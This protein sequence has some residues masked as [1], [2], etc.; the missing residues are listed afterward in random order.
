[1][2]ATGDDRERIIL[3]PG[4][5]GGPQAC[6][7]T[8]TAAGGGFGRLFGSLP[9]CDADEATIAEL[10]GWL[11]DGEHAFID[12][13]GIPAGFT[14]FGQFVD[15]D[16]TFDHLSRLGKVNEPVALV[17]LR[18]PCLDLDSVYGAGPLDQPFLYDWEPPNARGA[19]LLLGGDLLDDGFAQCDLPRNGQGR[20][21]IGDPRN[22]DNLIV[23]QLHLLFIRF[24]NAVVDHLCSADHATNAELFNDARRIVCWHYQWIVAHEYLRHI[25]GRSLATSVLEPSVDGGPETGRR[26][27]YSLERAPFIPVEFSGAVF[28]FSHSMVRKDYGINGN[29]GR[30]V[31]IFPTAGERDHL[32]GFR[33][34]PSALVIEWDRF[35]DLVHGDDPL[36]PQHS[37]RIDTSIAPALFELPVPARPPFD[38]VAGEDAKALPWLDLQ[39]GRA[40]GL[41]SGQDVAAV[42][43]VRALGDEQLRLGEIGSPSARATLRRAAPLWYYTLCEAATGEFGDTGQHLGP[44]GGRIVAE[45]LVGLLE[46]DP[47]SYLRQRPAWRPELPGA[48]AGDFTMADLI[49]FTLGEAACP[50]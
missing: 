9:A 30:A 33:W 16:I 11:R 4:T 8:A 12:D 41:P 42:M 7:R 34:I 44:V 50:N 24:H 21:V 3:S 20:A 29:V 22:D 25:V 13:T 45:V 35:F 1:M 31:P 32:T 46:A 17:N 39:R 5:G 26:Q 19:K 40:L 23:A 48:H 36:R 18:T 15:H 49:S 43:G 38:Q 10:F 6:A 47:A 2:G 14:Y 27:H 28:R 37:L